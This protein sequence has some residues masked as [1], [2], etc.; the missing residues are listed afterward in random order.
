MMDRSD[1]PMFEKM[2]RKAKKGQGVVEYAGALVIAVAVVAAVIGI[3][4]DAI[5]AAFQTVIDSVAT[6]LTPPA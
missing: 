3:G 6:G 2:L 5:E 4:P 1:L